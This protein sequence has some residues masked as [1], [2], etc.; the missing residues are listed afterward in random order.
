MNTAILFLIFNRPDTTA[1]VFETIRAARPTK[2]YVAADG[3]RPAKGEDEQR[4]CRLTR[5][6]VL[7]NIDWPCEVHTLLR[8]ENLGCG[9]S[10]Y[11]AMQWFFANQT[12][13]IVIEDDCLAHADFFTFCE[14]MLEKYRNNDTIRVIAGANYD[15]YDKQTADSYYFSA[16]PIIG[17]WAG[18]RRSWDGY[19]FDITK[20]RFTDYYKRISYY[21]KNWKQRLYWIYAF[22]NI[23]FELL[24][25]GNQIS[26]WDY[27]LT[28]AIW[29]GRGLNIIPNYSTIQNIGFRADATHT[30]IEDPQIA[31][32]PA[33]SIMP[34]TY[35]TTVERNNLYD[36]LYVEKR[37]YWPTLPISLG[38]LLLRYALYRIRHKR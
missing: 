36:T 22:V 21:F 25:K 18:W 26:F 11:S 27:Q 37:L 13:G 8:S 12:E 29:E 3:P 9:M 20:L 10:P 4:A 16:F 15:F 2:L 38:K 19:E 33:M 6:I 28:M 31:N 34:L 35:P 14:E 32:R 23:K 5:S 24:K 7:D 30:T 17:A 1:R